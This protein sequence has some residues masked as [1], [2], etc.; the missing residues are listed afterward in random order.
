MWNSP[1]QRRG[2][3]RRGC[4]ALLPALLLLGAGLAQA[5]LVQYNE[6]ISAYKDQKDSGVK[7][8]D[9]TFPAVSAKANVAMALA[10]NRVVDQE[11]LMQPDGT[12]KLP[13]GS[14]NLV[15]RT[16]YTNVQQ[17]PNGV[18]RVASPTIQG[19]VNGSVTLFVDG[20][21]VQNIT[22]LNNPR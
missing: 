15:I 21:G 19:N 13:S 22:V 3:L 18:V 2:S 16:N 14:Q 8:Q 1:H 20:Q 6:Q 17:D 11:A 7:L 5:Q 12:L 10:R 4:R 9:G